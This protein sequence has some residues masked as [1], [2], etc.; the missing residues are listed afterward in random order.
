VVLAAL[1][2]VWTSAV[3][4]TGDGPSHVYNAFVANELD[5]TP[6]LAEVYE[7]GP[8]LRP[9][10]LADSF[11]RATGPLL[12]WWRSERL[13]FTLIVLGGLVA[14]AGLAGTS[15]PAALALLVWIPGGWFAWMGFYD[16]S[17]GLAFLAMLVR[18][19]ERG[20]DRAPHVWMTLLLASH[21]FLA[22]CGCVLLGVRWLADRGWQALATLVGW[23][24]LT[25]G[26]LVGATPGGL[27]PAIP[28]PNGL[29]HVLT[30]D[31]VLSHD[32]AGM[33][34]G[35]CL[36][37]MTGAGAW[38]R[39]RDRGARAVLGW[40]GVLFVLAS[41]VVPEWIGRGG[42]V[43][44]R[45]RCV[46]LVLLAPA[47]VGALWRRGG[48]ARAATVACAV[49]AWSVLI[50]QAVHTRAYAHQLAA[51]VRSIDAAV[52]ALGGAP[53]G[54]AL[55]VR[56]PFQQPGF[57]RVFA[58][59]RI[60]ERIALPRAWPVLDDYEAGE[61]VFRVRW[62]GGSAPLSLALRNSTLSIG[63]PWA[64]ALYLVHDSDVEPST[65]R[66]T[67][68]TVWTSPFATTFFPAVPSG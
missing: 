37:L 18:S 21:L 16:F 41:L 13:L 28:A 34:A 57:G 51:T 14:L 31:P 7:L 1:A 65:D 23:S 19:L 12:G 64:R 61:P 43:P 66:E 36:F 58:W 35:F 68:G 25:A 29:A 55:M 15:D 30:S 42:Y 53:G 48:A 49:A 11:L 50:H 2:P 24:A 8:V 52:D 40:L 60:P 47:G 62:R 10:L 39:C 27:S 33:L 59:E 44:T 32:P 5:R 3:L 17:I 9:Q 46:A 45:M 54:V 63:G 6:A 4:P 56:D 67:R 20:E 26:L 22:A 38:S